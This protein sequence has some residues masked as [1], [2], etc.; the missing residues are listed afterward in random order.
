M[1]AYRIWALGF[2]LAGAI[3]ACSGD[4]EST[5]AGPGGGGPGTG[6]QAPTTTSTTSTTSSSSGGG[7]GPI[8]C[9]SQYTNVVEEE[10]NILQQDCPPGQTCRPIKT[11]SGWKS[12]CRADT[13]LKGPGKSCIF[14]QECEAGL[15]CINS[16]NGWC[17][18]ACCPDSNEP[19]GGGMCNVEADI[20]N[21]QGPEFVYMCSFAP[22]CELLTENACASGQECHL[23][24]ATQGLATCIGP[25][26]NQS[27]EGGPCQFLNDCKDMQHCTA[28]PDNVCRYY[29]HVNAD[30]GVPPGLGGC[31]AGESCIPTSLGVP[32][33]GLCLP[34]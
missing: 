10:C 11:A 17:T 13:G 12:R 26:G 15:F 29:C 8:L 6:G 28:P 23:S 18:P 33:V 21:G 16:P 31:P 2:A 4:D 7:S 34:M 25:S 9:M 32:N 1:T 5:S 30:P 22:E 24:D 3:A 19:C 27:D 14:E 20:T